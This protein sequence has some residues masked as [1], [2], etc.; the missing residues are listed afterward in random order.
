MSNTD[1]HQTTSLAAHG[2]DSEPVGESQSPTTFHEKGTVREPELK[3]YPTISSAASDSETARES[4]PPITEK[5]T[6]PQSK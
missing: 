5:G 6:V 1:Q 2:S 4:Q 3:Q